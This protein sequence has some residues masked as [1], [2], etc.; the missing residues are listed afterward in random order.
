MIDYIVNTFP[1]ANK[2][3][4]VYVKMSVLFGS[5]QGADKVLKIKESLYGLKQSTH[6]IFYQHFSQ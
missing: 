3:T 6:N 2:D 1:Q 5:K 4:D